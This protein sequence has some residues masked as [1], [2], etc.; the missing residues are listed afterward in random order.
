M[1]TTNLTPNLNNVHT[2]NITTPICASPT[3]ITIHDVYDVHIDVKTIVWIMKTV[4]ISKNTYGYVMDTLHCLQE[5]E[6]QI[7][8]DND[9]HDV[10]I[11]TTKK[12]SA[13]NLLKMIIGFDCKWNDAL[14]QYKLTYGTYPSFYTDKTSSY[15]GKLILTKKKFNS[16][17][18]EPIE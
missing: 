3:T 13:R 9:I 1:D 8:L 11:D 7:I 16:L 17:F 4:D 12:L 10:S 14:Q 6:Q 15:N 2:L 5:Y 18:I